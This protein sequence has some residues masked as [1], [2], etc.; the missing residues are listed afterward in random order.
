MTGLGDSWR[1]VYPVYDKLADVYERM[2]L[3]M[4]W[5]NVDRWRRQ[6]ASLVPPNAVRVLDAGCGPGNMT[7][8]LING[9]YVV[10]LD[11]SAD[12]L[13]ANKLDVDKVQGVFEALPF[14]DNAFDAAVLAYSLH[15]ARDL[16]RALDEL[17]RVARSV[18]AVS[19]GK[20]DGRM[21]RLLVRL[22]VSRFV[23]LLAR[24]L[25]PRHVEEYKALKEIFKAALPNEDLRRYLGEWLDLKYFGTR[26]LGAIYMFYG[27][28]RARPRYKTA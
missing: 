5:G 19:M 10:G 6:L 25:A 28:R 12:M 26:G 2:N 22:Y 1:K 14:R 13:K 7:R 16:G 4:T 20:P 27:V 24:L 11:Y 9:R 21:A 3:A 23:P 18:A 8:H 17:T 15:A